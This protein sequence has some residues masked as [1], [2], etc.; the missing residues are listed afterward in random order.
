MKYGF[1]TKI[2]VFVTF[3]VTLLI[4]RLLF[5][6]LGAFFQSRHVHWYKPMLFS[7]NIR[8]FFEEGC[9]LLSCSCISAEKDKGTLVNSEIKRPLPWIDVHSVH[10]TYAF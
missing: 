10:S 4:E 3:L 2:I 1:H 9:L 7:A 5:Y 8:A 6:H